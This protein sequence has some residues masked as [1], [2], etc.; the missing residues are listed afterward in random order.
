[1]IKYMNFLILFFLLYIFYYCYCNDQ[2]ENFDNIIENYTP[3]DAIQFGDDIKNLMTKAEWPNGA[4]VKGNFTVN[5]FSNMTNLTILN[6]N[7]VNGNSN[8]NNVN[9][10]GNL[11]IGNSKLSNGILNVDKIILGNKYVLYTNKDAFAI[12]KLVG[13]KIAP[14]FYLNPGSKE[15]MWIIENLNSN[16]IYYYWFNSGQSGHAGRSN[17]RPSYDGILNNT[18]YRSFE[19]IDSL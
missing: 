3:N 6:D 9:I 18:N 5:G 7:N 17:T 19:A 2:L 8:L 1:M 12:G 13:N 15:G 14:G 16:N 4:T 10:K 11:N